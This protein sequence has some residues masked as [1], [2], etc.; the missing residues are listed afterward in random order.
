[1]KK[2]T[3][4]TTEEFDKDYEKLDKS[5]RIQIDKE[6]EQL[7]NNPYASKPLSYDFFREK[8]IRNYRIYFLIYD[9]FLI[10]FVIAISDKKDQQ[11]TINTIKTLIPFY[12][13][14]V[15]KK[16]NL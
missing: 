8:K 4:Y 10:V 3:I 2:Y 15:K 9:D 1:M 11:R 6:I 5:L 16:L 13:E 14:E 12:R 7:E